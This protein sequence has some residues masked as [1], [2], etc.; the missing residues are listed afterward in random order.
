MSYN[1]I[2]SDKES[3]RYPTLQ[4]IKVALGNIDAT[5]SSNKHLKNGKRVPFFVIVFNSECP[6]YRNWCNINTFVI[7]G[8]GWTY[9]IS[10]VLA[11]C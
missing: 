7:E 4:D 9:Y 3:V 6:T 11:E 1:F 2:C 8:E 10:K 5:V